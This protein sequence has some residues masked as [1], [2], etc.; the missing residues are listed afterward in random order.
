MGDYIFQWL[1]YLTS[2]IG[3]GLIGAWLYRDW[4]R[5][6]KEYWSRVDTYRTRKLDLQYGW[7][8]HWAGVGIIGI[9]VLIV[10]LSS[11][12]S[13]YLLHVWAV[14]PFSAAAAG[15]AS[16]SIM[17]LTHKAQQLSLGLILVTLMLT[18]MWALKLDFLSLAAA[19][20]GL[21]LTPIEH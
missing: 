13:P 2:V 9:T 20:F 3:A 1:Q 8:A 5:W 4:I 11:M 15:V 12:W 19:R 10:K 7:I 17:V 16:I 18:L 21:V 6:R 14:A